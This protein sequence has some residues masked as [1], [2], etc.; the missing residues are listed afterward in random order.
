MTRKRGQLARDLRAAARQ[1]ESRS[2]EAPSD[3][4]YRHVNKL[5]EDLQAA[6]GEANDLIST[7]SKLSIQAGN[8]P[9]PDF[10]IVKQLGQIGEVARKVNSGLTKSYLAVRKRQTR[11]R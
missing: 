9:Q 2:T 6:K 4:N 3:P 5:A 10:A 11:M 8:M 1:V 7:L